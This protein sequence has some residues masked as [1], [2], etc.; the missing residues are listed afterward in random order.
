MI[1]EL[2]DMDREEICHAIVIVRFGFDEIDGTTFW[3]VQ[4]SWGCLERCCVRKDCKT[5]ECGA[6]LDF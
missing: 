5:L 6:A 1:K 3:Q 2:D 4:N